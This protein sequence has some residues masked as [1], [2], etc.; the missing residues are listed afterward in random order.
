MLKI[1]FSYFACVNA[2]AFIMMALDK[3]YAVKNKWRI[4]EYILLATALLGGGVGMVTAMVVARH[5]L[6][7]AKFRILGPL[8]ILAYVILFAYLIFAL[9]V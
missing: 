4:P 1:L 2:L 9:Y 8:S 3:W 7:K 6:S 5:K